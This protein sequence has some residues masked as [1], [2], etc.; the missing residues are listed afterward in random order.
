MFR[1]NHENF[2]KISQP[3]F[4][5]SSRRDEKISQNCKSGRNL[6]IRVRDENRREGERIKRVRDESAEGGKDMARAF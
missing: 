2:K 4:G 5:G 6:C 3:F 1:K